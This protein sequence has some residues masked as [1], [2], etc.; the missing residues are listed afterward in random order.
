[1]YN[2]IQDIIKSKKQDID[3]NTLIYFTN[4]FYVL[5]IKNII[6]QDINLED[7][8]DNAL[9]FANKVEFYNSEHWVYK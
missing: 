3:N 5:L 2:K 7:F 6:P 8:I 1:M 4:Y 9:F